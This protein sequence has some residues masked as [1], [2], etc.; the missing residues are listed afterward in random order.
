MSRLAF[1]FRIDGRGRTA[2][3]DDERHLLDLVEQVL[4]T[5]AGERVMRPTFGSGAQQ[6]VFAGNSQELAATTQFLVQG[7][8]QQWLGDRIAVESVHVEAH[9]ATL[10]IQVQYV[11]RR[12]QARRTAQITTPGGGG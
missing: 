2:Q 11:D 8:L 7:A 3:C 5:A 9:E 12:T 4:L 1:P 6:L 10:L